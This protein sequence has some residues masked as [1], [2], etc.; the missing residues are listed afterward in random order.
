MYVMTLNVVRGLP[1]IE[2]ECMTESTTGCLH[3]YQLAPADLKAIGAS[4]LLIANGGG[5]EAFIEKALTQSPR[6][7]VVEASQGIKLDFND[8]PHVWLA[9]SGAIRETRNIAAG[10]AAAD[11]SH[12]AA[13]S[14]NAAEYAARL[15]ELRRE[16]H[17]AL[18]GLK[19]RD[20]ITF[21]EAFPY[22]ATEFNLRVAAVVEREPGSAP[23]AG[24]LAKTIQLVRATRVK[25]IFT[26][27]Q[28]PAEER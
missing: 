25:A 23:S 10:L 16:M 8:N 6:L 20:I 4:D 22:F 18:D 28:Y 21:H 1:G 7:K 17:A 9:V 5:M 15:E 26:E 19:N 14:A 3:D 27:P 13:Y 24:E 2:V 12:A 11:P